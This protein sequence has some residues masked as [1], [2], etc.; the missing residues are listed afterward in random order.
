MQ[1]HRILIV[2]DDKSIRNF[3]SEGLF[4]E[5]YDCFTAQNGQE[6]VEAARKERPD[7]IIMDV[8]MPV[9]NGW[10]AL[11]ELRKV[12]Q[13]Q[14][15]P[16]LMLTGHAQSH[17]MGIAMGLGAASYLVKPVV[18]DKLLERVAFMLKGGSLRKE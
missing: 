9:L 13:T 5:G 18:L 16:V 3:I 4:M 15:M 8:D 11:E 17:D 7:L 2:D 12:P 14:S 10:Q 1:G 6:G